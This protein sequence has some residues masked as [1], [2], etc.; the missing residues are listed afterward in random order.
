LENNRSLAQ[1]L[2]EINTKVS[3]DIQGQELVSCKASAHADGKSTGVGF[4][5][6]SARKKLFG[7]LELQT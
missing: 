3:G 1:L 4:L 5:F 7:A 2:W 6:S